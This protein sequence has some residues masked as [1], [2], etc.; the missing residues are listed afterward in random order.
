[1]TSSAT[2]TYD[3]NIGEFTDEAYERVGLD[4]A[5]LTVRHARSARRSLNLMFS[6]WATRGVRLFQVDEQTQT[7]TESDPSYSHAS[8]TLTILHA[9]IRRSDVDTPVHRIGM[10]QYAM[11]PNK[12]S[13]GL[14][15]MIYHD[16]GAGI[17]YLW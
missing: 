4:P 5:V 17:Y 13:E 3:P 14:P 6:E 1:M 2:Y 8:G 9:V 7:L 15:S 10:E 12:T 11:L 16:R